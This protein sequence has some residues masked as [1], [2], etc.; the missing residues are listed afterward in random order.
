MGSKVGRKE[1]GMVELREIVF[2]KS[3]LRD[4]F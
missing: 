3:L 4:G 1:G 2:S